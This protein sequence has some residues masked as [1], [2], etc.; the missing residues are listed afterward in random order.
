MAA[1]YCPEMPYTCKIDKRNVVN[2]DFSPVEISDYYYDADMTADEF[3]SLTMTH[4]DHITLQE[5]NRTYFMEGLRKA[6]SE[7]GGLWRRHDRVNV[8]KTR[9]IK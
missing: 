6:V 5:P 1:R 9:R 2:Y 7:H 4:A 8:G 3:V